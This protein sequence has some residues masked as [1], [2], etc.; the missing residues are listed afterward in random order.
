MH[1]LYEIDSV[2]VLSA[3][4]INCFCLL[5]FYRWSNLQISQ[6]TISYYYK[7]VNYWGQMCLGYINLGQSIQ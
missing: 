7:Y 4:Q 5:A 1:T 3:G 6:L 2:D